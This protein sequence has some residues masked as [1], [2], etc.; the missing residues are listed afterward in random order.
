MIQTSPGSAIVALRQPG[1]MI[2]EQV[3][4][5]QQNQESVL[6]ALAGSMRAAMESAGWEDVRVEPPELFD[7]RPTRGRAA[8][9]AIRFQGDGAHMGA[10]HEFWSVIL[11][12][13]DEIFVVT[14]AGVDREASESVLEGSRW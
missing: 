6:E 5:I 4:L 14:A 1:A 9:L 8:L 11:Y 12:F 3:D 7:H 13:E 2:Q 10:H